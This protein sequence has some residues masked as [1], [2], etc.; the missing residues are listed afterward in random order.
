[1]TSLLNFRTPA[2]VCA[3]S[4]ANS[5]PSCA[6]VF[7]PVPQDAGRS[8]GSSHRPVPTLHFRDWLE[9]PAVDS[10]VAFPIKNLRN[11]VF[12]ALPPGT[13]LFDIDVPTLERDG[14]ET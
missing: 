6:A 13:A 8:G 3:A 10:R 1:M 12:D 7:R 4:A 5:F 2:H 11:R 14:D 9:A